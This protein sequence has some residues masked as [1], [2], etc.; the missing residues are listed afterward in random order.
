MLHLKLLLSG[1][2]SSLGSGLGVFALASHFIPIRWWWLLLLLL[3]W[4][5]LGSLRLGLACKGFTL[6]S[7]RMLDYHLLPSPTAVSEK[8]EI[9]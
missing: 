5:G 3:L 4:L 2:Q 6:I 9:Y 7:F 1:V 8:L